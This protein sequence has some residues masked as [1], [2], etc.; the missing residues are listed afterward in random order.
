LPSGDQTASFSRTPWLCVMLRVLPCS[1]GT[2][3]TSPRAV[4][5]TRWPPGE[6]ENDVM[7]SFTLT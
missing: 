5:A 3:N 4:K 7:R 1:A 6:S 2:V